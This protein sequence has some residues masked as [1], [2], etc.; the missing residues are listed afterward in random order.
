MIANTILNGKFKF[1][2]VLCFSFF[3]ISCQNKSD[4]NFIANTSIIPKPQL[5]QL[6][7]GYLEAS[8][9]IIKENSKF[10]DNIDFFENQ[11]QN[12]F[13]KKGKYIKTGIGENLIV[14]INNE[15]LQIKGNY[16]LKVDEEKILIEGDQKGIFYGFQTLFQLI[17]LN[18]ENFKENFKIPC[19]EIQDS[20]SF[21]HRGFLMD[22]CRHFFS[23]E[24][25]KKYIDLLAFYKMNVLHWHLTEDQGWRIEMEKYPKLNSIGSFRKD[26]L[27]LYGGFYTKNEIKEIV[28]YATERYIEIIPEIELPGHS[29]AA[30]ASYPYLSCEQ[31][32]VKVANTWGVFKD[33]YCAGND[34]V[35]LF[36]ENVF[37]EIVDLFPSNRIHIGGDEAPKFRWENC[38]KCQNRMKNENL[39]D[40]HALQSYFIERIA[41]ILAKKNRSIIGWDEILESEISSE[42]SIQS[43]RGFSG[44]IEAVKQGKKAIMSPTSHCYFDYEIESIDLEKVYS[45]S[46]IPNGLDSIE[47]TLIIGGECNLWSERIPNEKELD[48]KSFPR[49]LAMSEVLWRNPK[50]NYVNFQK[51]VESHYPILDVL[52][53]NYGIESTPATINLEHSKKTHAVIET[54]VKNLKYFFHWG[55]DSLKPLN[56]NKTIVNSSGILSIQAFKNHRKYGEVIQQKISIHKGIGK[57]VEYK[58][59]FSEYYKSDGVK[60]LIDGKLGS[61]NFKD[62]NWQGF[63]GSN[64]EVVLDLDTMTSLNSISINFYQYI[65]SWIVIPKNI[66]LYK[67]T[68]QIKWTKVKSLEGFSE[69]KKRGKFIKEAIFQDLKIESKFIKIIAENFEELPSWHEAAGSK[70]WIFTDEIIIR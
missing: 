70:C 21:S 63:F 57:S 60:A 36:L 64:F 24:T 14:N 41:K 8:E 27:G 1:L 51:R 4:G 26:S 34:S 65:N 66:Q 6:K 59:S 56:N 9:F 69:I 17:L 38:K 50:K 67:S 45:F 58:N 5:T 18:N 2:F 46:P 53:V 35:F 54:K 30:I 68:D 29:T 28:N 12:Y 7:E 25:I 33:I 43:W 37:D 49:L 15:G 20:S 44:G 52:N 61:L 10:V 13:Q 23:L 16:K 11:F 42:V 31:K 40:E 48:C 62:G 19:L 39:P 47:E 3:L 22:C 32:P 55:D